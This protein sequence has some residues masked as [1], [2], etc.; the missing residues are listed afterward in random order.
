MSDIKINAK[1]YCK[2]V[3][4]AAK[5]PHYAVNGVLLAKCSAKNKE[6]EFVDAIPLFHLALNL[7]PMAEVALTQVSLINIYD[8]VVVSCV[9]RLC[10]LIM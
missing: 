7:T 1:A 3:L 5:Y 8:N 10:R 9:I 2:L 6:I 4:H